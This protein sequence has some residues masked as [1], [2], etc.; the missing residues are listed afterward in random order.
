MSTKNETNNKGIGIWIPAIIGCIAQIGTSGDNSVL[1]MSTQEFITQLGATMDQVQLANIV[2]SLLA[3]ALMVFGGMLGIAKGFKK[4]FL[5]G[6][7]FACIGEAIAVIAPNM[8]VLIWGARAITGFGAALLVPSVLG[9]IVSLYQG[10]DRAIAFGGVGAATGI[11]VIV[12]PIGAGLVMDHFGYQVAYGIMSA[13][14]LVVFLAGLKFIPTIKS[15]G[16]RVD[17]LGTV[18]MSAGLIS[19]IIGCSKISVWGLIE[20]LNA[21]FT[22]FGMSPALLFV[23]AGI[24]IVITTMM[25]EKKIEDKHGAALIPQSFIKTRQVRNGLYITGLIFAIFGV[26]FFVNVAWIMV[27]AGQSGTITG[28]AMA[29][30]ATPMILV[31]LSVPKYFFAVSPRKIVML[32]TASAI[33][34]AFLSS[35]SLQPDGYNM[36]LMYAGLALFGAGLGG[37]SSQS[38]MIVSSALN[39]RDAA[40]SSGIQCS[41]RNVWQAAAVSIIGSVLL[42]SSSILFKNEIKANALEPQTQ[43]YVQEQPVIGFMSNTD[44]LNQLE[45]GGI[46]GSQADQALDIYKG[47]RM[48]S[49]QY[50]FWALILLILIHIPGFGAVPTVGWNKQNK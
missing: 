3:G 12:M 32:S 23:I 37:Y 34:G 20:P 27:V 4:T 19:F 47:T 45:Q 49:A 29:I 24:I 7:L 1:G 9:I 42:F 10:K 17:Y 11:A 2:Y 6:A 44:F 38:A 48:K 35:M 14:F 18:C 41:T 39:Q 30:M 33:L 50:S 15:S 16:I 26:V 21:P 46:T 25:M 8:T 43:T 31:S 5:A 40:Q 36:V 22:V 28:I 13:W